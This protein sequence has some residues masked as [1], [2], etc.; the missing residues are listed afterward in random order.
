MGC[1]SYICQECNRP[2]NS[3][4]FIGENCRIYRLAGG[5]VRQEMRGAYNSYGSVFG[6]EWDGDWSGHVETHFNDDPS[7]GF[8]IVHEKCFKSIPTIVS[9][10]DPDQ[11]WG[12]MLNKHTD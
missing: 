9:D 12:K 5:K 10:D 6:S 1:F 3:D 2:V 7:S 8:A 4:S 11:G